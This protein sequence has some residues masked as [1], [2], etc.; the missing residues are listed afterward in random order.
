MA[1]YPQPWALLARSTKTQ[2]LEMRHWTLDLFLADKLITTAVNRKNE[3]RLFRVRLELLPEMND[4][5]VNRARIRIVL[6]TPD[7]VQQTITRKCFHRMGHKVREQRK[8]LCREFDR[9]SCTFHFIAP[10]V[11]FN[12]AEPVNVCG[13]RLR[14]RTSQHS[15]NS[16]H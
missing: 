11:N 14:R 12:I 8:L 7:C 3:A 5:R 13:R 1:R 2:T 4:V 6:I 10:H 16:R 9:P 15:F